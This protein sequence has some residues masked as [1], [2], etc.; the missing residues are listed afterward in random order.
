MC[1]CA[2]MC[3]HIYACLCE[4]LCIYV[5]VCVYICLCMPVQAISALGS[6]NLS[7]TSSSDFLPWDQGASYIFA[8]SGDEFG[9]YKDPDGS[10]RLLNVDK[11]VRKK[12]LICTCSCS[13]ALA[14]DVSCMCTM[15]GIENF[16]LEIY[17][18]GRHLTHEICKLKY[19]T[20]LLP[21]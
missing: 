19:L 12:V 1:V 8:H 10:R 14:L 2:P 3:M 7:A 20:K 11:D 13:Q 6:V 16:V 18:C 15:V 4:C 17:F 9:I 5:C 21:S